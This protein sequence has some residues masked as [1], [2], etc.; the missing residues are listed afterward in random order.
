[1]GSRWLTARAPERPDAAA[2]LDGDE[3]DD[4]EQ[5]YIPEAVELCFGRTVSTPVL[6]YIL[7]V[8]IKACKS[9]KTEAYGVYK[10]ATPYSHFGKLVDRRLEC[11]ASFEPVEVRQTWYER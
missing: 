8:D 4:P 1:M 10:K 6:A 7:A 5:L 11:P 9:N 2:S 3:V